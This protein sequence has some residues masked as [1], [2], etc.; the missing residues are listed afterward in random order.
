ME[1]LHEIQAADLL[2]FTSWRSWKHARR[3]G[4]V[5][6]PDRQLPDGPRWSRAALQAWLTRDEHALS[7]PSAEREAL[8]RVEGG[9]NAR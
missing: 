6:E 9:Q 7:L 2:G 3:Q 4:L 8:R 5:P 1:A